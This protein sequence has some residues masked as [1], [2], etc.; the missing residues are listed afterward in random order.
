MHKTR[1][2]SLQDAQSIAQR[3]VA[4]LAAV[5]GE[6]EVLAQ[7]ANN[8]FEGGKLAQGGILSIDDEQ[9]R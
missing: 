9:L 2:I 5:D 4:R 1:E 6:V 7:A 8:E 3:A